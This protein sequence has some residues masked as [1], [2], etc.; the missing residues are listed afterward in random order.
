MERR[1]LGERGLGD[2][3]WARQRAWRQARQRL[4]L[5]G[6]EGCDH[7]QETFELMARSERI[8]PRGAAG[9]HGG[10]VGQADGIALGDL[11]Q[12]VLAEAGRWR[13]GTAVAQGLPTS[14]R[15][16]LRWCFQLQPRVTEPRV[17]ARKVPL[18][19]IA[20]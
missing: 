17:M 5:G 16:H 13:F 3:G 1:A 11:A 15:N 14:W 7:A 4:V 12:R 6:G 10:E 18:I 20:A 2:L 8:Q 9:E 19:Q